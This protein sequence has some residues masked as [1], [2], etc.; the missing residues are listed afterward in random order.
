M[1]ILLAF[2]TLI[3]GVC[4]A[5]FS[6]MPLARPDERPPAHTRGPRPDGPAEY[7]Q[8]RNRSLVDEN[9]V[10]PVDG[11]MQAKRHMDAM[12]ELTRPMEAGIARGGWWHLGPGNV[13]GRVRAL[14]ISPSDPLIILA[15]TVAGGI[16]R[17][18]DGGARWHPADDFMANLAVSSFA[19][20]PGAPNV[21]YAGTGEGYYNTDGIRGA[22]IF[23]SVNGGGVWTQLAATSTAPGA[24]QTASDYQYVNRLAISSN[25]ATLL[26][27]TRTGIFRSTDGGGSF[28]PA[29]MTGGG[30]IEPNIGL[31]DVDFH[32]TDPSRAV[33]ARFD[34]TAMYSL[35]G[36][37]TWAVATGFPAPVSFRRVETAFAPGNGAIVY[38]SVDLDAGSMYRSIDGGQSFV[39]VFDG[40][41][42]S[43]D[44]LA[45]QGWYDNLLSVSPTDENF[46]I[47]GGIDL[48]RSTTGGTGFTKFSAWQYQSLTGATSAHAD[49]H[50]AVPHPNF[51]GTTN[52]TFFFANDGGIYRADDVTTAGN[53]PPSMT[54]GWVELNNNF[55]VTQFY[56]GAGHPPTGRIVGG[57]QDNGTLLFNPA[58][59]SA[60]ENWTRPFGGDGGFSG[61]DPTD[62]NY[63]YG[64][65]THLQLH[66]NTTG[67][68]T[69]SSYIYAGLTDAGTDAAEFIAAFV[70][71]P[72]NSNRLLAASERLWRT[73]NVKAATPAW[74]VIKAHLN[75]DGYV[76]AIAV[77]PGNSNIVYAGHERGRV[78]KTVI[79]NAAAP[80]VLA[81][82]TRID[83]NGDDPLP[84]RRITRITVDPA[85]H[86]IV[87]VTLGGFAGNNI[88]RSSDAGASWQDITGPTGG[89]TSLPSVPVRDLEVHPTNSA[90][91]YAG[92]EVGI[93]ASE[94]GGTS[95]AL[96]HD[97]P[98]NAPVDELFFM[99]MNLIAVTHGRGMFSTSTLGELPA[100]MTSPAP[101]STLAGSTVAFTWMP[102]SA[103]D[104]YWLSV[105]TT[106]AG[107]ANV[108]YQS[109]G[110]STTRQVTGLPTNGGTVYVRLWTHFESVGWL[111]NDYTYTASTA[112]AKA[113]MTNPAPSS[114]LG[115]SIV[116]FFW[117]AGSG[118]Q[119]YW[120]SIGTTGAGSINLLNQDQ[121]TSLL[122]RSIGI[123]ANGAT[124]SVRLWTR[125][126]SGWEFNDY[127][128]TAATIACRAATLES[129]SPGTFLYESN[130]TFIWNAG[131]GNTQFWLAAGTTPGGVNLFNQ[132]TGTAQA[133][134]VTSIPTNAPVYLRLWSYCNSTWS[135]QD[136]I[137][138][139]STVR[140]RLLSPAPFT[141]LPG[142]SATFTWVAGTGSSQYWVSAGNTPGGYDIWN[143]GVGTALSKTV[144]GIPVDGR[145]VFLRLWSY[146]GAWYYTD[147]SFTASGTARGRL[148]FPT[149]NVILGEGV[150]FNWSAGSSS[151]QYWVYVGTTLGGGDLFNQNRGT[152]L[153]AN[154]GGLPTDHRTLYVRLWSLVSGTWV[155]NDYQFRSFDG[156]PSRARM[157]SPAA[158]S[159]LLGS[160]TTFRWYAA[161]SATQY[162]LSVG[163]TGVGS[164]NLWYQSEGVATA[165]TVMGIPTNGS[166]IYVRLWTLSGGVWTYNDYDYKASP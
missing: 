68:A 94:D 11:L 104:Q 133:A 138:N 116:S 8:W 125:F 98:T 142:S 157:R 141:V 149:E 137:Y 87:Y 12:R 113:A 35:D 55:A 154:I 105:G 73:N 27:A 15:G 4:G 14:T 129:P 144:T 155:Y 58:S 72:N 28:T 40:A 119:Q 85:N 156:G 127:T 159:A 71:D 1:R 147:Y 124:I 22:G 6:Q 109:Q 122:V 89:A 57:T 10:I 164:S 69:P 36:G 18:I 78:Y 29:T 26:A 162:W 52:R 53:N 128:Y 117:T 139:Q 110:T 112:N 132:N 161:S 3:V 51:N 9:G 126:A 84:S 100:V 103:T 32:P 92:T 97:G 45:T 67:G 160:S 43:L 82:W 7:V 61:Y 90:W 131:S 121:G 66:R 145:R 80:E 30:G 49:H 46:V 2:A 60:S 93:F 165:R 31:T 13:G 16:W 143:E 101:G 135:Y 23:K 64:E 136:D 166:T 91:L 120:L 108:F 152:S 151:A 54:N 65:Y 123:P 153:T 37:A 99:G 50:I 59:A 81:S 148:T 33:A 34:G 146:A 74:E 75:G 163:T 107:S 42:D 41:G 76:T 106:G 48:Y 140:A 118:A 25:G 111:W 44:P 96:P 17:T 150:T 39:E 114:T 86:D 102:G 70:L 83:T 88:Y 19:R 24:G 158:G 5:V 47:W 20:T 95:W 77:A 38:A 134:D 79:G 56:G 63:F 21:I 115:D 130:A 62:A